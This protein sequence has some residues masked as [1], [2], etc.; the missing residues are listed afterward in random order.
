[1][2]E[3]VVLKNAPSTCEKQEL[4]STGAS[5]EK[6]GKNL[7]VQESN[8]D[9]VI[10]TENLVRAEAEEIARL[11]LEVDSR[12]EAA[13]S[14]QN[15]EKLES[16]QKDGEEDASSRKHAE[17]NVEAMLGIASNSVDTSTETETASDHRIGTETESAGVILQT[18]A[19]VGVSAENIVLETKVEVG[20]SAENKPTVRIDTASEGLGPDTTSD[21]IKC[22]DG[23]PFNVIKTKNSDG[24]KVFINMCTHESIP[25]GK[26]VTG[27]NSPHEILDKSGDTCVGYDICVSPE[28][29]T[30]ESLS[31]EVYHQAIEYLKSTTSLQL[32]EVFKLPKIK[33][34]F[35]GNHTPRFTLTPDHSNDS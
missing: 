35:K 34:N 16:L 15:A 4:R 25:V 29:L 9:A 7:S 23:V 18:K 1:L 12:R 28:Y 21:A 24:G 10:I 14:T 19:E 26:M 22:I 27:N 20:E 2:P 6:P 31:H 17:A 32:D 11:E 33:G 13:T 3:R 30:N 5:K 8:I